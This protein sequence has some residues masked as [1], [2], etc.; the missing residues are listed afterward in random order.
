MTSRCSQRGGPTTSSTS[1]YSSRRTAICSGDGAPLASVLPSVPSANSVTT[2]ASKRAA[3]HTSKR[4]TTS[5][6][7]VLA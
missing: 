2:I 5:S 7:E 3:G 4:K 1:P 6:S